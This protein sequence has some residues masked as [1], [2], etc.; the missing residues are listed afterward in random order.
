MT[1][2]ELMAFLGITKAVER[3]AIMATITPE[4]RATYESM[5][6]VEFD[7]K[8]WV[9]GVGPKPAGVIVCRRMGGRR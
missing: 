5:A 1:D 8:L 9:D 4:Q 6:R 2:D 3:T 7:L